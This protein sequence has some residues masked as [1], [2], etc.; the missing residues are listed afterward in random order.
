MLPRSPYRPGK[1]PPGPRFP[2]FGDQMTGDA[3]EATEEA[4]RKLAAK[5]QGM[6]HFHMDRLQQDGFMPVHHVPHL[7]PQGHEMDIQTD[8]PTDDIGVQTDELYRRR[9]TQRDDEGDEQ[10][11]GGGRGNLASRMASSAYAGARHVRPIANAVGVVG[12]GIAVAGGYVAG[13]V[14]NMGLQGLRSAGGV[15]MNAMRGSAEPNDED[16]DDARPTQDPLAAAGASSSGAA[17]GVQGQYAEALPR[18]AVYR[19]ESEYK[20]SQPYLATNAIGKEQDRRRL[21]KQKEKDDAKQAAYDINF[22]KGVA[23]A[24]LRRHGIS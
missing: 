7:R 21:Q 16:D 9:N 4:R 18:V 17:A 11:T 22:Q 2:E 24:T 10:D 12:G 23:E 19:P 6:V 20:Q 3:V 8:N 5:R 13:A 14:A 15:V 1:Y